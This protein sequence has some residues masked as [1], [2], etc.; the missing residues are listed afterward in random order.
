LRVGG[1]DGAGEGERERS[2]NVQASSKVA[3]RSAL[4]EAARKVLALLVLYCV[5]SWY[6][7]SCFTGTLLRALLVLSCVLYW[8]FTA[9]FTGTLLR[10]REVAERSALEISA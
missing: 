1:L 8:Y 3:K 5:L 7:T 4:D 6:F 10:M 9:C 2:Q